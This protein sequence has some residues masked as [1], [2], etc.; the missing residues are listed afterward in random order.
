[1]T[2]IEKQTLALAA[3]YQA[4]TEV[5]RLG[6]EGKWVSENALPLIRALYMFTPDSIQDVISVDDCQPG[7]QAL[8]KL[9]EKNSFQSD[10]RYKLQYLLMVQAVERDLQ[11]DQDM[12]NK[13][14]RRLQQLEPDASFDWLDNTHIQRLD[15]LY[16]QTI[17]E[18]KRRVMVQGDY[19]YLRND[20]TAAR[21]RALLLAAIRTTMLWQQ[22]GGSRWKMLL[23]PK[24]YYRTAAKLL[25]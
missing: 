19:N 18:M 1:M 16:Q 12:Q 11:K 15:G 20:L 9:A 14:R 7:L 23:M 3:S 22:K 10:N 8:A 24:S 2:P 5:Y 17:S 6:T 13:I 4:V 21:V 25:H